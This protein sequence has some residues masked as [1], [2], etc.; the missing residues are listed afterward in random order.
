MVSGVVGPQK[1]HRQLNTHDWH[2]SESSAQELNFF[3]LNPKSLR[4][5]NK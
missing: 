3:E 2:S 1:F 5:V 4:C